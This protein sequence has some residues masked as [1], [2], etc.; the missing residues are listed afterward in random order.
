MLQTETGGWDLQAAISPTLSIRNLK[1]HEAHLGH[2]Q[3]TND[4]VA[5]LTAVIMMI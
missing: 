5:S 3:M 2:T 4:E 1:R